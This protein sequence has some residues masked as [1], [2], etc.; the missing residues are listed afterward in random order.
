MSTES[1]REVTPRGGGS[2]DSKPPVTASDDHPRRILDQI[3]S[4]TEIDLQGGP[5]AGVLREEL[6]QVARRYPAEPFNRDPILESL[7]D[8]ITRSI[9]P[10]TEAQS[11]RLRQSVARTLYDDVA[12]RVRIERLWQHLREQASDVE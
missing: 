3:L 12:S 1:G 6:L 4:L 5:L 2:P 9:Q 7:V 10:L 11:A 8:V